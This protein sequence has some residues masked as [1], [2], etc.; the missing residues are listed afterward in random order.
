MAWNRATTNDENLDQGAEIAKM[1]KC[2]KIAYSWFGLLSAGGLFLGISSYL[3]PSLG[4]Y[5]YYPWTDGIGHFTWSIVTANCAVMISRRNM[6]ASAFA[7]LVQLLFGL[8][9]FDPLV[10]IVLAGAPLL[11]LLL[12][13]SLRWLKANSH[14]DKI[15]TIVY[16]AIVSVGVM[17]SNSSVVNEKYISGKSPIW[18]FTIGDTPIHP[19]NHS[20]PSAHVYDY[21]H[22]GALI[23]NCVAIYN[24]HNVCRKVMLNFSNVWPTKDPA[25]YNKILQE[26]KDECER[27]FDNV[28]WSVS[29]E[30]IGFPTLHGKT[31]GKE[32]IEISCPD[33]D[34]V[35]CSLVVYDPQLLD[36]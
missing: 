7:I 13:Q 28:E 1:P 23:G 26:F 2:I 30:R 19:F 15:G 9:S 12:P 8:V 20:D 31:T 5:D 14:F 29:E 11:F 24:R 35:Y 16:I 33:H 21:W 3:F 18:V 4:P 10:R 25:F 22:K 34:S 32:M 36:E 27:R 17:I 6:I